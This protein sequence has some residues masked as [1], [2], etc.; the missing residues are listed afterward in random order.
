MYLVALPER[1]T[2]FRPGIFSVSFGSYPALRVASAPRTSDLIGGLVVFGGYAD[3]DATIRFNIGVP[4]PGAPPADPTSLAG[5]SLNIVDGFVDRPREIGPVLAGWYEF[6]RATWGNPE[7]RDAQ[8]SREVAQAIAA[9]MQP[10]QAHFFLLGCG[11]VDGA[12]Q[13]CLRA[14]ESWGRQANVDPRPHLSGL[15]CPVYVLH[16]RLDDVIPCEES[17][18]LL[19]ALPADVLARHYV[20]GL[21]E[22]TRRPPLTDLLQRAPA[23][24]REIWTMLH[25]LGALV[26]A[27]R[28]Q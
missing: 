7:F 10:E 2:R 24:A 4:V 20:T 21:Y 25:M 8:R 15:H 18:K 17:A 3:P 11:F 9:P 26:R 6:A 22:H 23:M 27:G 13:A 14:L 1:P 12:Q 5:V 28:S 16:S 19:H